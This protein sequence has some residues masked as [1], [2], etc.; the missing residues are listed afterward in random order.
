M[1]SQK[2]LS[3]LPQAAAASKPRLA[4]KRIPVAEQLRKTWSYQAPESPRGKRRAQ[5]REGRVLRNIVNVSEKNRL[6]LAT[7]RNIRDLRLKGLDLE[8]QANLAA[9]EVAKAALE[10]FLVEEPL[11]GRHHITGKPVKGHK[12]A[13]TDPVFVTVPRAGFAMADGVAGTLRNYTGKKPKL[14]IV[15]VKRQEGTAFPEK[16]KA[17]LPK[18]SKEST[19]FVADG[20]I[21]SGGTTRESIQE[22]INTGVKPDQIV[23]LGLFA[24]P[25][26]LEEL[27]HHFPGI[28]VYCAVIDEKLN[29]RAFIEPGI[30]DLGDRVY[31]KHTLRLTVY[32]HVVQLI[33]DHIANPGIFNQ[34]IAAASREIEKLHEAAKKNH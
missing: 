18:I 30:G 19:V 14:G 27:E 2:P 1:P 13:I 9:R 31:G 23:L 10:D 7:V 3:Q 20:M 34:T 16:G 25:E 6:L 29:T 24:A 22:L 15:D 8:R 4:G 5:I 12:V 11:W 17:W 26:G 33:K 28:K 32:Q 21:A